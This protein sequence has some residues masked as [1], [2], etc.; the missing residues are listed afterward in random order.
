MLS[1]IHDAETATIKTLSAAFLADL[2]GDGEH[3]E[4]RHPLA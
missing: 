2:E 4:R 3:W 1:A